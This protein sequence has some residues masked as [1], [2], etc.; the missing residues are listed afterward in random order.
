[1]AMGTT[2]SAYPALEAGGQRRGG[3]FVFAGNAN[4]GIGGQQQLQTT[5]ALFSISRD[6]ALT[7]SGGAS[8]AGPLAATAGDF[9]DDGLVDLVVGNASS[10]TV[11]AG[12]TTLETDDDGTLYVFLSGRT[13]SVPLAGELLL[14]QANRSID[15]VAA[16]DQLGS[17]AATAGIDINNDGVDDLLFA[18]QTA[19][20]LL[21]GA[22]A[23]AG[24]AYAILG[25]AT[26]QPLPIGPTPLGNSSLGD[27]LVDRQTGTL[28]FP[29]PAAPNFEE[30]L[31]EFKLAATDDRLW[32]QFTT[33]GDGLAGDAIR[34]GPTTDVDQFL[35][36]IREATTHSDGTPTSDSNLI[37]GGDSDKRIELTFDLGAFRDALADPTTL[38]EVLLNVDLTATSGEFV[39]PQGVANLTSVGDNLYFTA[40]G[41]SELWESDATTGGTRKVYDLNPNGVPFTPYLIDVDGVLFF[42]ANPVPISAPDAAGTVELLA[43]DGQAF[44]V[45]PINYSAGI[46]DNRIPANAS[47]F[48]ASEGELF[49]FADDSEMVLLA[50]RD[51]GSVRGPEIWHADTSGIQIIDSEIS[52]TRLGPGID[53]F[54]A[55]GG[56]AFFVG[57]EIDGSNEIVPFNPP[58]LWSTV[59]FSSSASDFN[60]SPVGNTAGTGATYLE[61]PNIFATFDD[62]VVVRARPSNESVAWIASRGSKINEDGE[63]EAERATYS[64]VISGGSAINNPSSPIVDSTDAEPKLIF[65]NNNG[66]SLYQIQQTGPIAYTATNLL[67][68]GGT[69]SQLVHSGEFYYWV[70]DFVGP[71]GSSRQLV[72]TDRA[73]TSSPLTILS[74]EASSPQNLTDVNGTLFYTSAGTGENLLYRM[75]G[76]AP[77][78]VTAAPGS[79]VELTSPTEL[80]AVG[81]RL[82]FHVGGQLWVVEPARASPRRLSTPLRLTT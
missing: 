25:Q 11:S 28:R 52:P 64:I 51:V 67:N 3:L 9:N 66:A 61:G 48:V 43:Y 2:N 8:L 72:R 10:A 38:A 33:A 81:D 76:T 18:A 13:D 80:Q 36:A 7:L 40:A 19:D 74:V 26:T 4:L 29:D 65:F 78:Q 47:Q 1:M 12:G 23:D 58:L 17:V 37:L 57:P 54:V 53:G 77:I 71:E 60:S 20:G 69:P 14:S 39:A 5:D 31:E 41:G 21:G 68:V 82:F 56:Q 63:S 22:R 35:A 6:A 73:T 30:L 50:G 45:L 34:L 42:T 24:R 16:G 49:F 79:S 44:N 46:T 15:G 59:K 70:N 27:F 62:V 32:Y 55:S 75:E